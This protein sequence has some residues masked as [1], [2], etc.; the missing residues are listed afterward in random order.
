VADLGA[1]DTPK[2]SENSSSPLA[3]VRDI[4]L[5][6]AIVAYLAGFIFIQSY[7]SRIDLPLS[8]SD[9]PLYAMFVYAAPVITEKSY[10][11]KILIGAILGVVVTAVLVVLGRFHIVGPGL[12]R[13]LSYGIWGVLMLLLLR[14]V[15]FWSNEIADREVR[16]LYNCAG[17]RIKLQLAPSAKHRYDHRFIEFNEHVALRLIQQTT[18]A[19]YVMR[20]EPFEKSR[21]KQDYI[22]NVPASDVKL[23]IS[24]HIIGDVECTDLFV[25]PKKHLTGGGWP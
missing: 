17:T 2:P 25:K 12:A 11:S 22:Y 3:A 24:H 13:L 10:F 8:A 21:S 7:Y 9:V 23:A 18:S 14:S 1:T 19:Y 15:F 20:I 16:N 4:T 5:V 6:G